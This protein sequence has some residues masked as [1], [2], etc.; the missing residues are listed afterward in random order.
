[1]NDFLIYGANGYAG[2]LIARE[3]VRRGLQPVLAGR[4]SG[5]I[6]ELA[7]ELHCRGRSFAVGSSLATAQHLADVRAVLNCAGPFAMTAGPMIEA[8]LT[9]ALPLSR[10]HRRDRRDRSGGPAARAGDDGGNRRDPGR[11]VRRRAE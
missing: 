6:G 1:M 11:G 8:C 3:A 4:N 2:G 5:A 9:A 7:A 10:H